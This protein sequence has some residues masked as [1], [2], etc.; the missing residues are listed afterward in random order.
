MPNTDSQPPPMITIRS[1]LPTL[2]PAQ[3]RVAE[4]VLANPALTAANSI[5][6]LARLCQTSETTVLR[7]CRTIGFSGFPEL[8]T[9]LTREAS[10]AEV[11]F[12]NQVSLSGDISPTDP[13]SEVVAKI[14]FADARA[15]ED[16][17][18]TLDLQAL[19][20]AVRAISGARRVDIF[21]VGASGFVGA[22]LQQKL[23]RIGVM[24]FNWQDSHAALTSAALLTP[25]DVAVAI[26]HS[27]ATIDTCD[28]LALAKR[29]GARTVAITNFS[30]SPIA[31]FADHLLVTAAR[32]TT[33]RS[34]ATTSRIAQLAVIDCLFVGIA[35]A[36]YGS[37]V[38]AL[39]LTYEAVR[40][41]RVV[42][43]GPARRQSR[44]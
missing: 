34:G 26:S 1:M 17:A 4:A 9:A 41:R 33:F 31:K 42:E 6:S 15:I 5:T 2:R 23:H 14:A 7:F 28:A 36:S 21:G 19:G 12:P 30:S 22:D 24:A 16:T 38:R 43:S 8:R 20:E 37:T 35:Q 25:A 29:S 27:G 32:E 3:K 44:Q 39:E 10:I 18:R 11:S 13:L 40:S